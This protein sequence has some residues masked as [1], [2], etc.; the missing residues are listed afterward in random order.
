ME[1]GKKL[2]LYNYYR[3]SASWRVRIVL[4]LKSLEFEYIPIH[5]LKDGGHQRTPEF[6]KINPMKVKFSYVDF[7]IKKLLARSCFRY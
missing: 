2:K 7:L 5:L 3:S 1:T 4:N 6:E